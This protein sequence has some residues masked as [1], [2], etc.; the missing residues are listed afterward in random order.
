MAQEL[1]ELFCVMGQEEKKIRTD[2]LARITDLLGNE[3]GG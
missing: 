3:F 2:A 1:D